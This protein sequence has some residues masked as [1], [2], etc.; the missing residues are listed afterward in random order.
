[1]FLSSEGGLVH[2]ATAFNTKSVVIITGYQ[3][4]E[5]V[6]YPQNININISK[7]GPCGLKKE[8]P[9]CKKAAEEHD[10]REIVAFIEREI[11]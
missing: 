2:A 8:C 10:W 7:H 3:S 1:M 11:M 4:E 6:A 5:M 9:E